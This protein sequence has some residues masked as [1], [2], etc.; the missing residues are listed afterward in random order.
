MGVSYAVDPV[1]EAWAGI[2]VNQEAGGLPF[3]TVCKQNKQGLGTHGTGGRRPPPDI[4]HRNCNKSFP[5]SV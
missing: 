4:L 2:G 1:R 5:I 3:K